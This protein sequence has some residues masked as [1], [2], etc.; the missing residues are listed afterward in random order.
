MEIDIKYNAIPEVQYAE[1]E[2]EQIVL[3]VWGIYCQEWAASKSPVDTGR[4]KSS[5]THQVGD[6]YVDV[7]TNVEYAPHQEYGTKK[8]ITGKHMLRDAVQDHQDE[9]KDI[10][11][12]ILQGIF[13]Q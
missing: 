6:G 12:R 1:Q 4:L 3:E 9:Y 10:A 5:F 2:A 8:G 11:E 13:G 7:G